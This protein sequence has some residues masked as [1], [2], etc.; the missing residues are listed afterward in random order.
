MKGNI[1]D[2]QKTI[3]PSLANPV[4]ASNANASDVQNA[5][6]QHVLDGSDEVRKF[7]LGFSE[8]LDS[9]LASKDAVNDTSRQSSREVAAQERNARE[10]T[11]RNDAAYDQHDHED[12]E[13]ADQEARRDADEEQSHNPSNAK[14]TDGAA[15][16][17]A[18]K[19][20]SQD[21]L[22]A[23]AVSD[24]PGTLAQ[25]ASANNNSS[26]NANGASQVRSKNNGETANQNSNGSK[27]NTNRNIAAAENRNQNGQ[28]ADATKTQDLQNAGLTPEQLAALQNGQSGQAAQATQGTP[29]TQA[30]T[31]VAIDP[32]LMQTAIPLHVTNDGRMKVGILGDGKGGNGVKAG[33]AANGLATGSANTN[34]AQTLQPN[35]NATT[36]LPSSLQDA[37][38]S[39]Q[40]NKN[41]SAGG[42]DK[43]IIAELA[44]NFGN[45]NELPGKPTTL[46]DLLRSTSGARRTDA[47]NLQS[48][49]TANSKSAEAIS[50]RLDPAAAAPATQNQNPTAIQIAGLDAL[51]SPSNVAAQSNAARS[52]PANMVRTPAENIAVQITKNVGS[53]INK[54]EIKLHPQELGRVDVKLQIG[55][56]GR[57]QAVMAVERVETLQMLQKDAG[58]LERALQDAGLNADSSS[59]EFTLKDQGNGAKAQDENQAGTRTSDRPEVEELTTENI[60]HSLRHPLGEGVLNIVA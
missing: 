9:R 35:A 2:L 59:M 39:A 12:Q 45:S 1:M 24:G 60:M 25:V 19:E 38:Q 5:N 21:V 26:D 53:G 23:I 55:H 31:R 37:A 27:E 52:M 6:R 54:F 58:L 57:I 49:A 33:N 30:S 46:N 56:D 7:E 22:A 13:H 11:A 32:A 51:K 34:S 47:T 14:G 36:P 15:K 20:H 48:T 28:D 3:A 42:P 50:F 40:N 43:N 16:D 44:R 18:G 10:D 4:M 41:Q 17:T 8:E 29:A